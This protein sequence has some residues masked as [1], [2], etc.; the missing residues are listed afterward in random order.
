M[1]N[2]TQSSEDFFLCKPLKSY[3]VYEAKSH[4]ASEKALGCPRPS[5]D[6]TQLHGPVLVSL[7]FFAWFGQ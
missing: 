1:Q 2:F 3:F 7:T 5:L 4:Q 6:T